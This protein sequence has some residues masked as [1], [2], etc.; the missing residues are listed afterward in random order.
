VEGGTQNVAM[1]TEEH[2]CELVFIRG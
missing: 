2:S 1:A